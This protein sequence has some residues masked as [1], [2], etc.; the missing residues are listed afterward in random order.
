MRD[1]QRHALGR[2]RVGPFP[3]LSEIRCFYDVSRF[4]RAHSRACRCGCRGGRGTPMGGGDG[5]TNGCAVG[6]DVV[7]VPDPQKTNLHPFGSRNGSGTAQKRYGARCVR[8]MRRRRP[9]LF[10]NSCSTSA[11]RVGLI[12]NI[13]KGTVLWKQGPLRKFVHQYRLNGTYSNL[14]RDPH[15]TSTSVVLECWSYPS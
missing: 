1:P 6:G 15:H 3:K 9:V 12:I 5:R 8:V 10:K 7:G 13:F 14:H 2:P 11:A 4:R